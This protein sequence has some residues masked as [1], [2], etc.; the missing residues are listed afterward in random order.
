MP[1]LRALREIESISID[2][3]PSAV[4]AKVHLIEQLHD[5]AMIFMSLRQAMEME[6]EGIPDFDAYI[7]TLPAVT[8]EIEQRILMSIHEL[9]PL[10]ENPLAERFELMVNAEYEPALELSGLLMELGAL[11]SFWVFWPYSS[12]KKGIEREGEQVLDLNLC[13]VAFRIGSETANIRHWGKKKEAAARLNL[14]RRTQTIKTIL[15]AFKTVVKNQG[16]TIN[17]ISGRIY[18]YLNKTKG[19]SLS[20]KTIGRTLKEKSPMKECFKEEIR[21]THKRYLYNGQTGV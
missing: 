3:L 12:E 7:E 6:S 14:A 4:K 15:S 10:Q 8:Q 17:K 11:W 20:E 9:E 19:N 18:N 5:Q 1:G 2:Q 21:G 16:D 13:K